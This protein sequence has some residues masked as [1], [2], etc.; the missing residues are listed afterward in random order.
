M[1]LLLIAPVGV[2]SSTSFLASLS[3]SLSFGV[4]PPPVVPLHACFMRRDRRVVVAAMLPRML[5]MSSFATAVAE[6]QGARNRTSGYVPQKT[7]WQ[8]AWDWEENGHIRIRH[9]LIR[10]CVIVLYR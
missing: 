1:P 4:P 5:L 10:P 2:P 9:I 7:P 6:S 8:G 3:A